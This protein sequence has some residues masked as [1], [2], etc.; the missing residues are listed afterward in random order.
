MS[1]LTH[2]IVK[3]AGSAVL[4]FSITLL[5][6]KAWKHFYTLPSEAK[7]EVA[8]TAADSGLESKYGHIEWVPDTNSKDPQAVKVTN[9]FLQKNIV[10]V[11]TAAGTFQFHKLEA[12]N[13]KALISAW[14]SAGVLPKSIQTLSVRRIRPKGN[15]ATGLSRH[16]YGL[17]IDVDVSELPLGKV[18]PENHPVWKM[19]S[20]AEGMGWV[21][22]GRFGRPDPQ[23][24]QKG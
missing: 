17:A 7:K 14:S 15:E 3:I 21:W 22:G 16:A 5:L 24:F 12:E 18:A 11:Q 8:K 2:P 9:D 4:G 6:E 19:A 1:L 13:L 23:H 20:I 10:P